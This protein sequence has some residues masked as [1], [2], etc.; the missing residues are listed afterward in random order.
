MYRARFGLTT[1]PFPQNAQGN[2]FSPTPSFARL[3]RRFRLLVEEPGVGLLTAESGLGKTSA[4]RNLCAG[5]PK[6]DHLVIYLCDTGVSPLEIYRSFALELGLKP[7]H[8]RGAL[9]ADLKAALIHK[10]EE[11]G[12]KPVLVLDEAHHLSDRF[13]ADLSAFLNF[14]MDSKNLLTLWLVGQPSLLPPLRYPRQASLARRIVTRVRLEPLTQ[15]ADFDAF[16]DHGLK[17]AGASQTLF[18]DTA[19]ELLFRTS[20]GLPATI[21]RLVREAL[22][23]AHERDKTFVDDAV[24]EAALDEQAEMA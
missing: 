17:A 3:A 18:T 12:V 2:K 22:R 23:M 7:S 21:A 15:R 24:L 4:I 9:W 19:Q 5:L 13:L 8:R 1:H 10:V 11:Q 14:A 6:P 20:R 16:L